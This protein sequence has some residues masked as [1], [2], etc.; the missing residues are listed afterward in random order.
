V[1]CQLP[2]T[3]APILILERERGRRRICKRTLTATT[4]FATVIAVTNMPT[5]S[6]KEML[7]VNRD[8][9]STTEAG[10]RDRHYS[11]PSSACGFF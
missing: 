3:F 10:A 5:R 9:D 1:L 6:V 4:P 2:P 11:V 7:V 8:G